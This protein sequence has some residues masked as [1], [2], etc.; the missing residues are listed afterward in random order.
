MRIIQKQIVEATRK[1]LEDFFP[2]EVTSR[3][4]EGPTLYAFFGWIGPGE[5][6]YLLCPVHAAFRR[7]AVMNELYTNFKDQICDFDNHCGEMWRKTEME[8]QGWI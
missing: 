4:A 2:Q 1:E 6:S 5:F 3:L 7:C 8:S